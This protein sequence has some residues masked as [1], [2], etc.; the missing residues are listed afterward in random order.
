MIGRAPETYEEKVECAKLLMADAADEARS[1]GFSISYVVSSDV[2][3]VRKTVATDFLP[4]KKTIAEFSAEKGVNQDG[5]N[6]SV[7]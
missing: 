3:G 7:P 1:L 6:G 2:T 4:A 5:L